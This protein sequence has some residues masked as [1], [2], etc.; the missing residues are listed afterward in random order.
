MK[1]MAMA[2]AMT[3]V[4]EAKLVMSDVLPVRHRSALDPVKRNSALMHTTTS[5][6]M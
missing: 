3:I 4:V 1:A 5:N 2:M 6:H